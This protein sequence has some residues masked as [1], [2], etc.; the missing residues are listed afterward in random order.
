MKLNFRHLGIKIISAAIAAVG[1]AVLVSASAGPANAAA[2]PAAS[3]KAKSAGP[4]AGK[5]VW[6]V[7]VNSNEDYNNKLLE[8][9]EKL[10]PQAAPG[11]KAKR[12]KT[13]DKNP[14]FLLKETDRPAAV[15]AGTGV[16]AS[17][18]PQVVNYAASAL[19]LGI[20][21]VI[22]HVP[23]FRSLR[24]E[25]AKTYR[26]PDLHYYEVANGAPETVAEAEILAKAAMPELVKALTE[27]IE[28]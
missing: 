26:V 28:K 8:A 10:L 20:P 18:T 21:T 14:F 15:I 11:V 24:E 22:V 25:N 6:V 2:K 12:V 4:W 7:D 23:E 27:Q 5:T 17:T 1:L 3:A 19:K 16:C 13:G 9:V